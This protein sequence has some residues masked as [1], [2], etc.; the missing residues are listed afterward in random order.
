MLTG[1]NMGANVSLNIPQENQ[2]FSS[3]RMEGSSLISKSMH[4]GGIQKKYP[5]ATSTSVIENHQSMQLLQKNQNS[6][7]N[8]L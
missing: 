3:G 1:R 4:I 7:F 2:G 8:A 6:G 5:P